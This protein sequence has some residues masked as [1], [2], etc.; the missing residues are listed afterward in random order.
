MLL[1][2]ENLA[3]RFVSSITKQSIFSRLSPPIN[4]DLDHLRVFET[5]ACRSSTDVFVAVKN[6]VR[7]TRINDVST[8]YRLLNVG[9]NFIIR[10]LSVNPLGTFLAVVGDSE[11]RLAP[12]PLLAHL[13]TL[14]FPHFLY[15]V[16]VFAYDIIKV[17]WHPAAANDRFLVVLTR[18][19]TLHCYDV[20]GLTEPSFSVKFSAH[21]IAPTSIAFG[22]PDTLT[23]SLTLYVSLSLAEIHAVYPFLCPH[24]QIATTEQLVDDALEELR[25]VIESIEAV[26]H[27]EGIVS[28]LNSVLQRRLIIHYEF[29]FDLKAQ[30][31]AK[32]PQNKEVRVDEC[33]TAREL[34]IVTPKSHCPCF[35]L[36]GPLF[37]HDA[38]LISDIS[39]FA[40][41][42]YA[43]FIIASGIDNNNCVSINYL[44]QA[45][46]LLMQFEPT[47]A[48]EKA[49]PDE[50]TAVKKRGYKLPKRGFGFVDA[51]ANSRSLVLCKQETQLVGPQK[52][53]K[54]E[55]EFLASN[56]EVLT[57][58]KRDSVIP[59]PGVPQVSN[60]HVFGHARDKISFTLNNTVLLL[61]ASELKQTTLR[62]LVSGTAMGEL[63]APTVSIPLVCDNIN[64]LVYMNDEVGDTGD[65]LVCVKTD[66]NCAVEVIRITS[67]DEYDALP[68]DENTTSSTGDEEEDAHE[69]QEAE[70]GWAHTLEQLVRAQ[71]ANTGHPAQEMEAQLRYL[72]TLRA[73]V[74]ELETIRG[75]P[76][77]ASIKHLSALGA[78]STITIKHVAAY[79]VFAIKLQVKLTTQ[80]LQFQAEI[81]ALLKAGQNPLTQNKIDAY[82]ERIESLRSRQQAVNTKIVALKKKLYTYLCQLNTNKPLPLSVAEKDWF[83]ELNSISEH[84]KGDPLKCKTSLASSI[85]ALQ[86]QAKM[87]IENARASG[88][89]AERENE[90]PQLLQEIELRN[91]FIRFAAKLQ[92]EEKLIRLVKHKL[93]E[94][95]ETLNISS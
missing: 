34:H 21:G 91:H 31:G 71:G 94:C 40:P 61:D 95:F 85:L 39:C 28:S 74:G 78:L 37:R 88:K 69:Q 60:L 64:S 52:F 87:Y 75:E 6:C 58:L 82:R 23:G 72:K 22:N 26:F 29:F 8:N 25:A 16:K 83:Q 93:G 19:S 70:Q 92:Q 42:T 9:A 11:I 43:T 48:D 90:A 7:V 49:A 54:Q 14:H 47:T 24:M 1:T 63:P 4:H 17:L 51:N 53:P 50:K 62:S 46:P 32:N 73:T 76:F 44:V 89:T 10:S 41:N 5:I 38:R 30:F 86:G 15:P 33:G 18:D 81:Q 68:D 66:G 36:Q 27:Y 56:F 59:A 55:Q 2:E 67:P 65:Y 35:A 45:S 77:D 79:A 3:K 84:L 13:D 57:L 20:L 80:L 12:V